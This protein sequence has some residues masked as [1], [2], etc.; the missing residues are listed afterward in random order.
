MNRLRQARLKIDKSQLQLM[1]ETKIYYSTIS[2]IERGWLS[3]NDE[4]KDKLAYALDVQKDWLFPNEG[5]DKKVV[6]VAKG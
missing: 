6:R 3:P 2:R 5:E 4:Q 1:R